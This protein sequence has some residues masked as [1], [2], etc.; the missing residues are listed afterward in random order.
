[1]YNQEPIRC[2]GTWYNVC[3][4][5]D[6]ILIFVILIKRST[7]SSRQSISK[8]KNSVSIP[9]YP[10]NLEPLL[11]LSVDQVPLGVIHSNVPM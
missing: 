2:I 8:N 4:S 3:D 9:A 7:I 1:M 5:Y 6:I 11:L 10:L